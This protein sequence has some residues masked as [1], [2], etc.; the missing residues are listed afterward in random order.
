MRACTKCGETKPLEAFPPVRRGE[1]KLQTWCRE[2]FAEANARNYRK[3]HEREKTRLVRQVNARRR[4]VRQKIIDYLSEHPCVDCGERDIVVLEFDHVR[5]KVADVSDYAAG[6]RSWPRV[7]AEIDKCEVR[8]AN[9]HRRKTRATSVRPQMTV[10]S[11]PVVT[12]P[13]RAQLTLDAALG[14]RTCR[15]CKA[16]KPLMEFPF[17]SVARQTRQWLCL[18]CQRAYTKDWY[19]RNRQKQIALARVRRDREAKNLGRRIRDYLRDHPCVDCGESEPDVLDFDHLRDKRANVSRLVHGAMSWD[20]IVKEIAKCEV[21]CANC[22]RRRTARAGG[23]Y[24]AIE[25][26]MEELAR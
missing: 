10:E 4:E 26:R 22:H 23:Y 21:R 14:L 15:V 17:R 1:P 18:S 3:N 19:G 25:G 24:R 5:E 7:K 6:G 8:C 12:Q 11:A 9:C 16:V 2:C 13:T 20:L